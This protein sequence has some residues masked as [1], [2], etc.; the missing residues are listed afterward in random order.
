MA[1]M[2]IYQ[3]YVANGNRVGFFVVRD[4]WDTIF[5]KVTMVNDREE[6]VLP[7]DPP[8][9][10]N[11]P[12]MGEIY[13]KSTGRLVQKAVKISCPGTYAYTLIENPFGR[14]GEKG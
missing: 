14:T 12:V 13:K 3:M 2:N 1:A 8:Y 10:G 9:H 7:G 6:G 5:A 4:S 11:P